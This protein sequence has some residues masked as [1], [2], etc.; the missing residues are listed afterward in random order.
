MALYITNAYHNGILQGSVPPGPGWMDI[1]SP[2]GQAIF[3]GPNSS[4]W[5]KLLSA[6][7]TSLGEPIDPKDI[8][9]ILNPGSTPPPSQTT[10]TT[11]PPSPNPPSV[12]TT[13]LPT[14]PTGPGGTTIPGLPGSLP[15]LDPTAPAGL[16]PS[17]PGNPPPPTVATPQLPTVS[18]LTTPTTPVDQSTVPT[19]IS[20]F[21]PTTSQQQQDIISQSINQS[22]GV[23]GQ[24][25]SQLQSA[26]DPLVQN[27]IQQGIGQ[28]QALA[29]QD[30]SQLQ[31]LIGPWIQQQFS[32]YTDPSNPS[33]QQMMGELNN[34][35]VASGGAL[36]QALA[37]RLAPLIS[38]GALQL[39]EQTLTPAFQS[40]QNM[41]S[42]GLGTEAGLLSGALQPSFQ[43][44]Q[45]LIGQGAGV[46]SNLG[47]DSLQRFIEEQNFNQQSTLANQLAAQGASSSF[48]SGI[49]GL[50][51]GGLGAVAGNAIAPGLGG[52]AV[53]AMVGSQGGKAAGG[54][55]GLSWI[56]TH[57]KKLGL[58]TEAEVEA[59]HVRLR[60][61][62]FRH[63]L[64]WLHYILRAPRLIRICDEA[65]LDWKEVK[66][67]L[68]D[69]VLAEHDCEKAW[70]IYRAE[71]QRLTLKYAPE[72]W[73]L[74]VSKWSLE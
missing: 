36:P 55:S 20:P 31:S 33:N 59:V 26:I 72:L 30:F 40:Q 71:C 53:G 44:Q 3:N 49:G 74:E 60:P 35:G 18:G 58:A 61:S 2:Q 42:G 14:V 7:K 4:M 21:V 54:G 56:C 70:Q 10:P 64:H 52:M 67:V 63:P 12:P 24:N 65:S 41:L 47:L 39:G 5:K 45:D 66:L 25:V 68:I 73:A 11:Q 48:G 46:Q 50:L 19:D 6:G 15:P 29:G 17:L 9:S 51:G 22:Q 34:A 43:N 1:S 16:P 62:I 69:A 32:Q 38:Q 57:L 37:S 8:Q 23:A 27:Q 28:S 13:P